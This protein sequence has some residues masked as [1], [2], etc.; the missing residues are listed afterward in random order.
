MIFFVN[1]NLFITQSINYE[2]I[3]KINTGQGTVDAKRISNCAKID[4]LLFFFSLENIFHIG[5]KR[6]H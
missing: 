6:Q 3:A 4:T 2:T 5:K 1:N